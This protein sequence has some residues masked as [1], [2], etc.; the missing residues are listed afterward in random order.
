[1]IDST[2]LDSLLEDVEAK[3]AELVEE[4]GLNISYVIMGS[5]QKTDGIEV[6]EIITNV[7]PLKCREILETSLLAVVRS[8]KMHTVKPSHH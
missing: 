5:H 1:M 4:S 7:P 8:S 3:V 6:R 2:E